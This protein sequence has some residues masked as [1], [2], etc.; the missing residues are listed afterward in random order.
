MSKS[1]SP[2]SLS[3]KSQA[4][5]IL[6]NQAA[7]ETNTLTLTKALGQLSFAD[8]KIYNSLKTLESVDPL[9]KNIVDA[10][11]IYNLRKAMYKSEAPV[12][13]MNSLQA[14]REGNSWKREFKN[15]QNK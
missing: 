5:T 6:Q 9:H 14:I 13:A 1:L 15:L 7:L 3:P 11:A 2:K 12:H 8:K 4:F 10:T